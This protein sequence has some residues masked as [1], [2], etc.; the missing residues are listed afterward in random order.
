MYKRKRTY[1]EG[2]P[3]WAMVRPVKQTRKGDRSGRVNR[4]FVPRNSL[5][6]IGSSMRLTHKYSEMVNI[7]VAIG[8]TGSYVF[9]CNGMYDP[10]V[11]GTGHQPLGFDE[12][13]NFYQHY[14]VLRSSIAV[15]PINTTGE[16][17]L[18]MLGV[19]SSATEWNGLSNDDIIEN[20]K[21]VFRWMDKSAAA[22]AGPTNSV[23]RHKWDAF[24]YFGKSTISSIVDSSQYRGTIAINPGEQ[25]FYQIRVADPIGSGDPLALYF[26]VVITYDAVW[27][28]PKSLAG[29]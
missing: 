4:V 17:M 14:T 29:S 24:K 15:I 26:Q 7:N 6:T 23:M 8:S 11:T 18:M 20:K 28:E 21:T 19:S 22:S 1:A 9:T 13:S 27:T 25:S 2:T 3:D 10:N 5:S 16:R 12:V